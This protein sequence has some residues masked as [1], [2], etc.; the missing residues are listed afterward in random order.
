MAGSGVILTSDLDRAIAE[1]GQIWAAYDEASGH[2]AALAQLESQ[3]KFDGVVTALA[4]LT[5]GHVAPDELAV[6]LQQLQTELSRIARAE[7]D[8]Q[9]TQQEI[10]KIKN[11]RGMMILLGVIVVLIVVFVLYSQLQ[12]G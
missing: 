1:R 5:P 11:Q 4:A 10:Q 12:G 8:I 6:A 7:A 3:I 9:A 2:G